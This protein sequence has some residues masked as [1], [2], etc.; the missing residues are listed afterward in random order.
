MEGVFTGRNLVL[1]A[2]L[3]LG[4]PITRKG[5]GYSWMVQKSHEHWMMNLL[6][7]NISQ[8]PDGGVSGNLKQQERDKLEWSLLTRRQ[9]ASSLRDSP[10]SISWK[11]TTLFQKQID[12]PQQVW[13]EHF[14]SNIRWCRWSSYEMSTQVAKAYKQSHPQHPSDTCYPSLSL[15]PGPH[16]LR[17]ELGYLECLVVYLR[18]S[19]IEGKMCAVF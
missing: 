5:S 9:R 17:Q 12:V 10:C 13:C 6:N 8:T 7:P 3:S 19:Y 4:S 15:K 14:T 2:Q 16:S 18:D 1:C 11:S